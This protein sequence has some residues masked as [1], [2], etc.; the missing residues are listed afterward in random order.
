[1]AGV[2][3]TAMMMGLMATSTMAYSEGDKTDCTITVHKLS[4]TAESTTIQTGNRIPENQ[5]STYGHPLNG[6]EFTLY[7]VGT[8]PVGATDL[9]S[10]TTNEE[11]GVVTATFTGS[12]VGANTATLTQEGTTVTTANVDIDNDGT[13]IGGIAQYISVQEKNR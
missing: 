13:E 6:V 3:S 1:M 8:L 7:K 2:L 5:V 10:V 9:E 12:A 11:T 4:A